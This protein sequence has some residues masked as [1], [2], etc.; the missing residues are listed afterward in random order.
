MTERKTEAASKRMKT[1]VVRQPLRAASSSD[2]MTGKPR[3]YGRFFFRAVLAQ[4]KAFV[5]ITLV[6]LC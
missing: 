4:M 6:D 1:V 3:R 2:L 5:K